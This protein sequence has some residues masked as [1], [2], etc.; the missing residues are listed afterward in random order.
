[1][2]CVHYKFSSKLN[3]DTVTFDGLN[4]TLADL[5]RQIMG[6]E[7]LKAVDCGL[8]I[9]NAQTK[10]EYKDDEALISKNS[11][12]IIRRIPIGGVKASSK[13]YNIERFSEQNH[14]PVQ[15][16]PVG[17][18][19][20]DRS[21]EHSHFS[22]GSSKGIDDHA[23]SISLAQLS[24]TANLAE[25]NA[26]ED[27]KIR[28][29]MSQSN[30]DYDPIHYVKKLTGPPPANYTCYRCGKNGHHIRN[31]PTNGNEKGF[32]PPQRIKK[33]TGIP[34]FLHEGSGRPV[35]KGSHV[36]QHRAL[37]HPYDRR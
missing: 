25:A 20:G 11:S 29:M 9:T 23:S 17:S 22:V 14:F 12:V 21:S 28:A 19:K 3:Y 24:K 2:S 5:K 6:R 36:D 31:C 4:I 26:S 8:Q 18:S 33:S 30:H 37:R 1:M 10:E 27:D 32:E 16:L 35:Y 34:P 7:R 15:N 13:M